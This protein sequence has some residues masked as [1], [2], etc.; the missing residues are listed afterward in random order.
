MRQLR[1]LVIPLLASLLSFTM[2]A[3]AGTVTWT[4]GTTD[5][6]TGSNWSGAAVPL[7]TDDVVIDLDGATVTLPNG[8]AF[9]VNSLTLGGG[10]GTTETIKS[11]SS[12]T[13]V[14]FRLTVTTTVTIASDGHLDMQ[15][16]TQGSTVGDSLMVTGA[17]TNNG[18]LTFQNTSYIS[19]SNLINNNLIT[20][21]NGYEYYGASE[22]AG[23]VTNNAAG[24]IQIRGCTRRR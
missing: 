20:A 9:T 7:S 18:L 13:T 17:I 14:G 12:A 10:T 4:G 11:T 21:D 2:Q 15:G 3:Q 8:T 23:N 16:S 1:H 22:I 24:E 5:W 6:N 19:T